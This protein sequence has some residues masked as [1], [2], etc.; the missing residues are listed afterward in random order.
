MPPRPP[1][2]AARD[3]GTLLQPTLLDPTA[4]PPPP[5]D[6][7]PDPPGFRLLDEVGRGGMGVVYRAR[8]LSLNRDVAVKL[9]RPDCPPDGTSARRFLAEARITAQ[10]QHPG[11]PAVYHVGTLP[12]GRPFLAMKLIRGQTLADLLKTGPDRGRLVAAFEDVCQA[13]GYAHA[14]GVLH[15]D[16]KPANVMV[17]AFGEVQVMDWG[18]AKV[19]RGEGQ[20]GEDTEPTRDGGGLS[21][22]SPAPHA[23]LPLSADAT[24]VG[25]VMG[26]PA[27]MAPEQ[28]T[29][30]VDR[31]DART[32]VF[33]LGAVLCVLLT[34]QPPFVGEDVGSTHQLA[35]R[36]DLADAFARLAGCGADP[37]LVALCKRCLN[38]DPGGRPATGGAVAAEVAEL[39]AA[40][41]DRARR[42]EVGAAEGRV[43]ESEGRRRRRMLDRKSV[44]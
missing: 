23:S 42:A 20:G 15:R 41:D 32:D 37:D 17:G 22:D 27:Y 12:D 16:L 35:A 26:T 38:V 19:L 21:P 43:R 8:D 13:V 28:A 36:A 9:L 11:I 39:R 30:A 29:G 3:H 44:V 18:L 14:H 6:R 34:G 40:A 4:A 1:P 5:L 10:L 31:L 7:P 33:G 2:P 25:S 24:R